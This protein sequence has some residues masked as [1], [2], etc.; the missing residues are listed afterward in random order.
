M[1]QSAASPNIT[2]SA[3]HIRNASDVL[4]VLEAVRRGIL[5]LITLRLSGSERDQLRSGNVFVWEESIEEGGLVRWTDGRRWSQSKVCAECLIYQEKVKVTEE[6]K[7]AKAMR[8]WVLIISPTSSLINTRPSKSGGLT[9]QTYSFLFR[10][11]GSCETRKWHVIAYTLWPHRLNLPVIEDYPALRTIHVPTGVFAR[12][13]ASDIV[14][15]HLSPHI[16]AQDPNGSSGEGRADRSGPLR[17]VLLSTFPDHFPAFGSKLPLFDPGRDDGADLVLPPISWLKQPWGS[18]PVCTVP[19]AALYF[20]DSVCQE[21][22][23]I[24]DSFRLSF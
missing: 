8:R 9:K 16:A 21:D 3:L 5:P 20:R 13:K 24:L 12:S 6:E 7:Q 4:V 18:I 10:V 11:P 23:R 22:R 17:V 1:Y 15:T 14:T 2:H 19:G